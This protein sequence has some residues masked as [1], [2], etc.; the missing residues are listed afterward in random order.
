MRFHYGRKAYSVGGHPL[1]ECLRGVFQMRQQPLVLGGIWFIAVYLSAAVR[2]AERVVSPELTQF[3][4]SEQMNRLRRVF[5][6]TSR[7]D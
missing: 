2:R 7:A 3:H 5:K 1:W 6:R 4:R